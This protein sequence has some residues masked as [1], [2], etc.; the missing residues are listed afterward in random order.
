MFLDLAVFFKI[1][2]GRGH[3][4]QKL[5]ATEKKKEKPQNIETVK[6]MDDIQSS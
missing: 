5:I 4:S 3:A 2:I 1:M 6:E